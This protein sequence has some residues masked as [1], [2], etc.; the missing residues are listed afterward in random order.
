MNLRLLGFLE[1]QFEFSSGGDIN[2]GLS[3][4]LF[5]VKMG[6]FFTSFLKKYHTEIFVSFALLPIF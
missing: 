5:G 3:F 6:V 2:L 4:F 1:N